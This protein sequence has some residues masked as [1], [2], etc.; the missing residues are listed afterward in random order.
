MAFGW[1]AVS[2]FSRPGWV[3]GWLSSM[4]APVVAA[5][6]EPSPLGSLSPCCCCLRNG[7]ECVPWGGKHLR[8]V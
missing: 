3:P 2:G 7:C 5:L 8:C 1:L 6:A 4:A